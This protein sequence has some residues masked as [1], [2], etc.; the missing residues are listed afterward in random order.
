MKLWRK[1]GRGRWSSQRKLNCHINGLLSLGA[2]FLEWILYEFKFIYR[3]SSSNGSFHDF[4]S[5]NPSL[6]PSFR[7]FLCPSR[8]PSQDS[9]QDLH[10]TFFLIFC[11]KVRFNKHSKVMYSFLRWKFL[12]ALKLDKWVIFGPKI[13]IFEVSKIFIRFFWN[14]IRWQALKSG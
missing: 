13:T 7:P 1:F 10:I 11:I 8:R 14:W 4:S 5:V 6:P 2:N 9:W 3:K 12:L